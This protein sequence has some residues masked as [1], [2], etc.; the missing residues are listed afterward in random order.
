MTGFL[1]DA[2]GAPHPRIDSILDQYAAVIGP[3]L[4]IYRHH[5]LYVFHAAT[6]LEPA[7]AVEHAEALAIAA[8]FHDIGLFTH[9]TIDY[10]EPSV[11]LAAAYCRQEGAEESIPLVTRLIEQHHKITP[12]RAGEQARLVDAFRRADWQFVMMGAYPGALSPRDHRRLKRAMPTPG[13]HRFIVGHSVAHVRSGAR[14]PLPVL[15]W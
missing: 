1:P 13:F 12:V 15:R 14:N 2:P 4:R 5:C 8:A 10:L 6:A 7:L 3:H 9:D 11:A